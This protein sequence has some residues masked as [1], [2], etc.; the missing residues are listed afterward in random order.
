MVSKN[1]TVSVNTVAPFVHAAPTGFGTWGE[2]VPSPVPVPWD[3][4]SIVA[5]RGRG[6]YGFVD[7]DNTRVIST[8]VDGGGVYIRSLTPADLAHGRYYIEFTVHDP[9]LGSGMTPGGIDPFGPA[10]EMTGIGLIGGIVDAGAQGADD[11]IMFSDGTYYKVRWVCLDLWGL[12][13][14]QAFRVL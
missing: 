10:N 4:V 9:A 8:T 3:P 5:D 12:V 2:V 11:V 6:I 7:N 13:G 1:L 14:L